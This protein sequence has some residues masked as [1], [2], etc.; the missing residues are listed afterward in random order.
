MPTGTRSPESS[1]F[2]VGASC[3][4]VCHIVI[5]FELGFAASAR[6]QFLSTEELG[7]SC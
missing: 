2:G 3:H 1:R 4:N 7:L 6:G 5:D